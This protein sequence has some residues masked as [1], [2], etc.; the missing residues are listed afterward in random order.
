M[1]A[2]LVIC[3]CNVKDKIKITK[4]FIKTMVTKELKLIVIELKLM[5]S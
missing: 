5:I 1:P 3:Y 4:I 2:T